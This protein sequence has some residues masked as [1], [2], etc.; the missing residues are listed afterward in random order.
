MNCKLR[1]ELIQVKVRN[2]NTFHSNPF[3]NCD[4]VYHILLPNTALLEIFIKENDWFLLNYLK[5]EWIALVFFYRNFRF[6]SIIFLGGGAAKVENFYYNPLFFLKFSSG[7]TWPTCQQLGAKSNPRRTS[8]TS[9]EPTTCWQ[10]GSNSWIT[11]Q[12]R[13]GSTT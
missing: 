5:N 8:K 13:L 1:E 4:S 7:L 10:G 11:R 2:W 3:M 6:F 12:I 9:M